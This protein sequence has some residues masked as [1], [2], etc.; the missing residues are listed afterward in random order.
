[1][2]KENIPIL[3]GDIY[4]DI[5]KGYYGG[6]VEVYKPFAE[7]LKKY[8][9]NSLYPDS[10]MKRPM[11]VGMPI[12]F[13]GDLS[14]LERGKSMGFVYASINMPHIHKPL[15]PKKHN[16]RGGVQSTIYPIGD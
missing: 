7:N 15:L 11:P 14:Y 16:L 12:Y 6:M 5:K 1:M 8:D 13:E 2:E 4:E 10:M 9:V 3:A